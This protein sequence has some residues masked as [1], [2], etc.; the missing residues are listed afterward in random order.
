MESRMEIV[1]KKWG[2][3]LGVRIP[4]VIAKDLNLKD[5]SSVDVEDCNGNIIITPKRYNLHDM[6]KKIDKSNV[7]HEVDTGFPRGKEIW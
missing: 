7:H 1:V 4:S 3:S 5:G 2:N 6:L